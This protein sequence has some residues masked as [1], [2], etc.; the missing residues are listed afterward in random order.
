LDSESESLIQESLNK[1][2]AN[3]TTIVIAHRLS[4]IVNADQ[5]IVV[6]NG[7]I[8]EQ[9]THNDLLNKSGAYYTLFNSQFK[10]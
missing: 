3:K 9:G 6:D 8:I 2:A 7:E 10:N 5:I 1:L 4:T